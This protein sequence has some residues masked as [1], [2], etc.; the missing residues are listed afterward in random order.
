MAMPLV[1]Q[2]VY[3]A[4]ATLSLSP[5]SA[6]VGQGSYLTVSIRENSGANGVNGVK[7]TLTYPANLL[8]F[9]SIS[10]S[11]A[12]GI[13]AANS[14]GGG[15][16][17]VER[18]ALPAVSGS[19]TVATV[20]FKAKASSGKATI[21]FAG[22]SQ[23]TSNDGS[24]A[25]ILTGTSGGNYTLTP[26]A[27]PGPAAPP[28][29]TIPPKITA[30]SAGSI[31]PTTA[32]ISWTTSE[33]AN[34]EVNY[35]I[36]Q[37]YGL[38][39]VDNNFVT[40]HKVTLNSALITPA[41]LYHY[42]VKSSD[43]AGNPVSG[44]DAIFTTKG[45]ALAI[46]V[47]DQKNKPVKGAKVEISNKSGVTDKNG[48]LNLS[49]F[50]IGKLVGTVTYKG[51][52]TVAKAEITKVDASGKAQNVTF[53]INVTNNYWPLLLV[54]LIII[55]VL[56]SF[57][58]GW[59]ERGGGSGTGITAATTDLKKKLKSFLARKGNDNQIVTQAPNQTTT[60]RTKLRS[61]PEIISPNAPPPTP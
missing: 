43:P 34:S 50:P 22:S 5:A 29:D 2:P 28:P 39:A 4:S 56:I 21:T 33:P 51:K 58:A 53:K 10:S 18:G 35:G 42:T 55:F 52:Q 3:A 7:A 60:P 54:P 40:D 38:A 37:N 31:T 27:A 47:I 48:Q 49:G 41:T 30:V 59:E 19:Q 32:I 11:S 16:V 57:F 6:S 46:T 8:D 12:F 9:V 15:S 23:V 36:N 14:G 44:A 45:A 61:E 13:I 17:N 25:N 26:P 24:G 1:A 20:R